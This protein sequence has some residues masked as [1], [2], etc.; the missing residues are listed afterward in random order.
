MEYSLSEMLKLTF[1]QRALLAGLIIG[2]S[3]G[4]FGSLVVL[5]KSSLVASSL[6][7]A[8][9]PGIAGAIFIAG[10]AAWNVFLG[11]M[12]AALVV[13]LA[14]VAVSRRSR[15]DHGSAMAILLTIAFAVGVVLTDHL[16]EGKRI[17]LED[18][19][20]GDIL[21]IHR[22]DLWVVFSIGAASLITVGILQRPILLTLFESN[23]AAA[24]GVPVRAINYLI[25]ALLVLVMVS[26]LQA[27][28][29][30]LSIVILVAPAACVFLIS[31]STQKMFWGGGIIG[32]AG[33]VGG[34][35]LADRWNWRPGATITLL[36]GTVFLLAF[37]FSPKNR[38]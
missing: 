36:L 35:L 29:C 16:P 14:S 6:S 27:V 19:L 31:N 10:L 30:I 37:L 15:L 22:A 38:K 12:L 9:L 23:V 7:H 28:G 13:V 20:F 3:S 2:F 26:S 21:N 5:K 8:L 34:I 33:C 24:Q 18:Y 32:A 1:F 25:M 4:A 11:A 17:N